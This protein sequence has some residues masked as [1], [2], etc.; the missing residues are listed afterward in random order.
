MLFLIVI[1]KYDPNINIMKKSLDAF[2]QIKYVI[3]AICDTPV[4]I[5]TL[6][7][8]SPYLLRVTLE[9]SHSNMCC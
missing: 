4:F 1:I 6:W 3:T 2:L 7:S 5:N 9:N 8:P